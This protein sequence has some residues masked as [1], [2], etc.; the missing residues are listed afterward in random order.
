MKRV[1]I[2]E[3]GILIIKQLFFFKKRHIKKCKLQNRNSKAGHHPC[4]YPSKESGYQPWT[5][6]SLTCIKSNC[7]TFFLLKTY[8][9][10]IKLT[11]TASLASSTATVILFYH[12]V[13]GNIFLLQIHKQ[14]DLPEWSI[15]QKICW[16]QHLFLTTSILL[17]PWD[18]W[19]PKECARKWY[20]R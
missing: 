16:H 20:V 13:I 8:Q 14:K 1:N 4:S 7:N 6:L 18:Q 5:S 15:K 2:N 19:S 3:N 9:I 17:H 10:Y 11:T 12:F